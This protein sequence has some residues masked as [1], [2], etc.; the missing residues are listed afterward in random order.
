MEQRAVG[1]ATTLAFALRIKNSLY[2]ERLYLFIFIK[3]DKIMKLGKLGM[4]L[5][6]AGGV[7]TLIGTVV[8]LV[9]DAQDKTAKFAEWDQEFEAFKQYE[10]NKGN[11]EE[12]E[13]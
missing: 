6:I 5:G 8:T 13:E 10:A 7:V 3:E 9:G 4:G 2:V 12:T 11:K 1:F